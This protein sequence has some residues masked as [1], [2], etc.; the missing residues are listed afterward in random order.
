MKRIEAYESDLNTISTRSKDDHEKI[1]T[2]EIE[3]KNL[4]YKN[5]SYESKLASLAR[6]LEDLKTKNKIL[7][8]EVND[9][10]TDRISNLDNSVDE[11]RKPFINKGLNLNTQF[12]EPLLPHFKSTNILTVGELCRNSTSINSARNSNEKKLLKQKNSALNPY[13]R[14][15][16]LQIGSESSNNSNISVKLLE[17]RTKNSFSELNG[18]A[19]SH[20]AFTGRRL[21]TIRESNKR[22]LLP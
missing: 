18:V 4:F 22:F 14:A 1:L 21:N 5:K 20:I 16:T 10:K 8:R 11:K 13:I 2:L 17:N 15:M 19:R 3:K 6:E 9:L 7:M 12:D